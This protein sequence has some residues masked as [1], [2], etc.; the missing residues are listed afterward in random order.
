MEH[1]SGSPAFQ[2]SATRGLPCSVPRARRPWRCPVFTC[3]ARSQRGGLHY[4]PHLVKQARLHSDLVGQSEQGKRAEGGDWGAG[5][6]F[7]AEVGGETGRG[8]G[9]RPGAGPQ[10]KALDWRLQG[11]GKWGA[12]AAWSELLFRSIKILIESK[13]ETESN[14]TNITCTSL[15][16]TEQDIWRKSQG[17][18]D[19]Q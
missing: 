8:R 11:A 12:G 9:L 16:N 3:S 2:T 6:V 18:W 1:S 17:A 7:K 15:E 13:A 14:H 5:G 19:D 10:Y 4:A